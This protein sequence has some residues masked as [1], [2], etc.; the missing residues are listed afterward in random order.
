[1]TLLTA[2]PEVGSIVWRMIQAAL[3]QKASDF[4]SGL[5]SE[6]QKFAGLCEETRESIS[7][8][9]VNALNTSEMGLHIFTFPQ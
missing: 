3:C 4:K 6:S 5:C 2:C 1:M 9:A 8:T 7:S